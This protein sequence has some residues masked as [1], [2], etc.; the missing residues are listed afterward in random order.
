MI[1]VRDT[2]GL[3]IT[4]NFAVTVNPKPNAAPMAVGTI[5]PFTFTVGE[6]AATVNLSSL[7]FRPRWRPADLHRRID[8]YPRGDGER[9]QFHPYAI[10][11]LAAGTTTVMIMVKDT[12]GLTI[13]RN[14]TVTVNSPAQPCADSGGNDCPAYADRRHRRNHH[15]HGS[16]LLG[17]R[18]R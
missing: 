6:D 7:L 3:T 11:P 1:M 16:P 15:R 9:I 12:A 10:T 5:N 18:W 8:E 13:T 4:R 17:S 2:G 14:I